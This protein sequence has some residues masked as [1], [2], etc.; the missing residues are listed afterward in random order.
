MKVVTI[1]FGGADGYKISSGFGFPVMNRRV[2]LI[3]VVLNERLAV[4]RGNCLQVG[5]RRRRRMLGSLTF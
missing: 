5:V 2:S 3:W 4:V 1:K